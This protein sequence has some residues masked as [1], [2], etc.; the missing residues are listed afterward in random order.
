LLSELSSVINIYTVKDRIV[1]Q[2][3]SRTD[4]QAPLKNKHSAEVNERV[5]VLK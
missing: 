4:I 2:F 1:R 5:R 3:S